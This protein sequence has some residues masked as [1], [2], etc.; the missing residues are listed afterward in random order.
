MA[1]GG[2]QMIPDYAYQWVW[3]I[4]LTI[5]C[6][7]HSFALINYNSFGNFYNRKDN[8]YNRSLLLLFVVTLFFGLR[9]VSILFA[10]MTGYAYSYEYGDFMISEVKKEPIWQIIKYFSREVLGLSTHM[11]FLVVAA[12]GFIFK[13]AACRKLFGP[14]IYTALLFLFTSFSFWS[15]GVTIIRSNIGMAFA[16]YGI[17]LFLKQKMKSKLLGLFFFVLAFY[18]HR[19]TFLLSCSFIA[20]YYFIRKLSWGL[21]IYV[22]CIALSLVYGSFF[23][24]LFSSL[25]F[26]DRMSQVTTNVDYSG[27]AYAGFRWD[28]LAYSIVPIIIGWFAERKGNIDSIY[29]YLLN[30]YI[31]SNAFW[32][33]VIRAQ[34]SD[35]FASISWTLYSIVLAYPLLKLDIWNKQLNKVQLGLWGQVAFLW[36][37][38]I[39]YVMRS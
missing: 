20:S 34:F 33:L 24:G 38:Q 13:F 35:R 14:H 7:N 11:W 25:G 15:N 22:G 12:I 32:V 9:P 6:I 36:L 16:V 4:F 10:D 29:K 27:F 3:Y 2:W 8:G 39:Y 21:F 23:E 18:S 28:F 30:A 17:A 1:E 5:L 26:D 37:M 31:L 19:S